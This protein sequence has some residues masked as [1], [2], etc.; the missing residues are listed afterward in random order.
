MPD[1]PLTRSIP[2]PEGAIASMSKDS[3]RGW[4]VVAGAFIALLFSVGVLI[5]YSFGVLST[6]IVTEFG[7]TN[8]QRST[9]FVAFSICSVIAGPVWGAVADRAGARRVAIVSAVLLMLCFLALSGLPNNLVI[10]H[11]AFAAIGLFGAG[12]LPPTYACLVVGW[13]DRHRGLA[14]GLTMIG[15]GAGATALPPIAAMIVTSYGWRE[16]C[17]AYSLMVLIISIPCAVLLLRAHPEQ[18]MQQKKAGQPVMV[19][20]KSAARQYRTWALGIFALITGCILVASVTN[21]VPLLQS[22]GETLVDAAKYQSIM[23]LSLIAGRLVGGA[24]L[25]RIFAPRVVTAILLV[26]ALGFFILNQANSSMA[27]VLAAVGI[28][29]A[30]GLEIDFLAFI[31]S[32]YYDRAAFTTIFALFFAVYSLGA[33]AGP[34]L[35]AWFLQ[36]TGGYSFGL[37]TSSVLMLILSLTMFTLPRYEARS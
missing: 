20:V 6:A 17:I 4:A 15:V 11:A 10:A 27:Y 36:T 34:P 30:I 16:L 28:G 8:I 23:G 25:D 9:L 37:L 24:L 3:S 35:F 2:V 31:A 19:T 22:R 29:L 32:R 18:T 13:F 5:V 21:F 7:W 14:L 33:T 12:T 26:T 1:I